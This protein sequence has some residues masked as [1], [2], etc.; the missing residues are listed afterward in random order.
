MKKIRGLSLEIIP[1]KHDMHWHGYLCS[2]S[3]PCQVSR[4]RIDPKDNNVIRFLMDSNQKMTTRVKCKNTRFMPTGWCVT[5][6]SQLSSMGI[7]IETD[8]AI[9]PTIRGVKAFFI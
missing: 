3:S 6:I 9:V 5:L 8:N 2:I 1:P 7:H 4:Y